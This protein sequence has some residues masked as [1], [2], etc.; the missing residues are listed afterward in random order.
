MV[1]KRTLVN[2][3]LLTGVAALAAVAWFEPGKQPPPAAVR[4]IELPSEQIHRITIVR[5]AETIRLEQE[6]DV[7]WLRE[8]YTL[9]AN[10]QQIKLLLE[11]LHT[12]AQASYPVADAD[13]SELGFDDPPLVITLNDKLTLTFGGTAPLN[14]QRY[15]RRDD[16]I[17][18]LRAVDYYPLNRAP[19]EF[20]S[21]ALLPPDSAITALNLPDQQLRQTA[22][23]W[24]LTPKDPAISADA[25][26]NL[27]DAWQQA[28]AIDVEPLTQDAQQQGEV[29]IQLADG[30]APLHF[31]IHTDDTSLLLGRPDLGLQ[32]SLPKSQAADLLQLTA[33]AHTPAPDSMNKAD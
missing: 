10:S 5:G 17:L 16:T 13:L 22:D 33:P 12:A 32:Y 9:R 3:V 11:K 25:I 7:W 1:G 21:L 23:G 31:L 30:K 18:L 4:L 26:Q 14:Y 20:V 19:V 24:Q 29:V 27:L 8:P 28:R 15:V 6:Q 2:L